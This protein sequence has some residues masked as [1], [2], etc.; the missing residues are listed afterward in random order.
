MEDSQ[1]NKDKSFTITKRA[2]KFV[3]ALEKGSLQTSVTVCY[4]AFKPFVFGRHIGDIWD[5]LGCF[6]SKRVLNTV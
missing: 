1:D 3:K 4:G 2:K 6:G 5:S